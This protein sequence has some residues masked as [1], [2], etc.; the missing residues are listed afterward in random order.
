MDLVTRGAKLFYKEKHLTSDN[1]VGIETLLF[2]TPDEST[3]AK[4][5]IDK[6]ITSPHGLTY[7]N[8]SNG[9]VIRQF[10]AG[11]T[12]LIPV[13]QASEK[14]GI[15]EELEDQV[16]AGMEATDDQ[17]DNIAENI[18]NIVD[19]LDEAGAMTRAYQAITT[20]RT[21]V[22]PAKGVKGSDLG[23]DYDHGRDG[24]Q[25]IVYDFTA[26][27]ASVSE[28]LS[29]ISARLDALGTPT[30]DRY[31]FLGTNWRTQFSSDSGIL[32]IMKANAANV[33]ISQQLFNTQFG[34]VIGVTVLAQFKPIAATVGMWI[35]SY[36]PGVPYIAYKGAT[37]APFFPA[38]NA[39]A[40]SFSDRTYNVKRGV[41]AFDENRKKIR[42][43]GD[44]V[45]DS[46]TKDDPIVTWVRGQVRHL[47]LQ[48]NIDHTVESTGTF[49]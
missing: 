32:E 7:R 30:T 5:R 18:E 6:L 41:L 43:F 38:D 16:A 8:S 24:A 10:E 28:A 40:G 20:K 49:A 37:P 3:A 29:D 35:L 26:G 44:M 42:A 39:F 46:F 4:V 19:G 13:P 1:G 15:D 27:G 36:D 11:T 12:E 2:S 17:M 14:V 47:Y 31:C 22:F 33:I 25:D 21:G 48:A 23:L 45:I 9:S 34:N